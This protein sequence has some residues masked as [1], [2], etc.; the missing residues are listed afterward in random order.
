[1]LQ[2]PNN[3]SRGGRS[4]SNSRT[5]SPAAGRSNSKGGASK[6]SNGKLRNKLLKAA[7]RAVG[8][9]GEFEASSLQN[10]VRAAMANKAALRDGSLAT[11]N[12][13]AEV[14][15]L[16]DLQT[17]LAGGKPSG[18]ILRPPGSILR[19]TSLAMR[20][21]SVGEQKRRQSATSF[22]STEGEEEQNPRVSFLKPALK[23]GLASK[24][25]SAS[26]KMAME[27][28]EKQT[29][30]PPQSKDPATPKSIVIARD[31]M[32]PGMV[33]NAFRQVQV[34][35]V[36]TGKKESLK[37]D[38]PS[39]S[40]SST[41]GSQKKME[42]SKPVGL[43][44]N[45]AV[46]QLPVFK[47]CSEGFF[48][49][50]VAGLEHITLKPGEHR[51]LGG[52]KAGPAEQ[53]KPAA[54]VIVISGTCRVEIAGVPVEE[55]SA[56]QTFCLASAL[57]AGAGGFVST[58]TTTS[59]GA[60]GATSEAVV[61]ASGTKTQSP[62]ANKVP[63]SG[64]TPTP[65]PRSVCSCIFLRSNILRAAIQAHASDQARL[66]S[67]L[68]MLSRSVDG[69]KRILAALQCH[70]GAKTIVS[71][72][73]SRHIYM[74]GETIMSQG[75][76]NPDALLLILSG[77]V[78][79]D[80]GGVEVRRITE[81]QVIGEDMLLNVNQKWMYSGTCVTP[82]D[83]MVLYRKPF[84]ALVKEFPQGNSAEEMRELQRLLLLLEGR[85][86]EDRVILSLPLFRGLD[87]EFLATLAKLMETRVV[88]PGDKIWTSAGGGSTRWNSDEC[89]LFVLLHGSAEEHTIVSP[90][91]ARTRGD[92]FWSNGSGADGATRRSP[93][94]STSFWSNGPG[95]DGAT[96]RSSSKSASSKD[97]SGKDRDKDAKK[98]RRPLVPGAYGGS[99]EILGLQEINSTVVARTICLT[100]ILHRSVFVHACEQSRGNLEAPD[101]TK[102]LR[103]ELDEVEPLDDDQRPLSVEQLIGHIPVLRGHDEVFM[104]RLCGGGAQRFCMEGQHLCRA[105]VEASE[106]IVVLRGEIR[107]CMAGI[108]LAHVRRGKGINLLALASSGFIPNFDAVCTRATEVWALS[109]SELQATLEHFPAMKRIMAPLTAAQTKGIIFA[110]RPVRGMMEDADG[111][112]VT[113]VEHK[114]SSKLGLGDRGDR[115]ST[116]GDA[117]LLKGKLGSRILS[118]H[119]HEAAH[120]VLKSVQLFAGCSKEF[121]EWIR[122]HL[123]TK[124][125]F[126]DDIVF[127]E[128]EAFECLFLVCK[129]CIVWEGR[130]PDIS[131]DTQE[132][133]YAGS[134]LGEP[135]LLGVAEKANG[136]AVAIEPCLVQELH[137]K[138]LLLGLQAFPDQANHFNS[139]A[140]EWLNKTDGNVLAQVPF[141]KNCTEELQQQ[142]VSYARTRLI[143]AG[144]LIVEKAATTGPLCIIRSGTAVVE[145]G[146]R[147]RT[148]SGG[149]L[150]TADTSDLNL[151][152]SGGGVFTERLRKWDA[153]NAALVM[154]L[155]G[156]APASI[157]AETF[158]A[159]A[160]IDSH[161]FLTTLQRFKNQIPQ[162][163]RD[164][165][166]GHLWP[167]EVDSVP[168][169]RN[170]SQLFFNRL[171][172]V[173][174][175][176]MYL[177]DKN[178]V[179][180]GT[181]GSSMFLMCHGSAES[182]ID[183]VV[184]GNPLVPG[185]V[186]GKVNFL[187][188][189]DKYPTT[190]R[191]QTVCHFRVLK[192][193]HLN[194]LL[195]EQPTEREI[196]EHLKADEKNKAIADLERWKLEVTKEK[197]RRRVE[198]AFR[199]HVAVAKKNLQAES[200][201][202]AKNEKVSRQ[203]HMMMLLRR[204]SEKM[205]V[206]TGSPPLSV[207]SDVPSNGSSTP[208]V[209][210]PSDHG[211]QRKESIKAVKMMM[212]TGLGD[213]DSDNDES[214]SNKE[215]ESS[216][217]AAV[218]QFQVNDKRKSLALK[219]MIPGDS[220]QKQE[221]SSR[222]TVNYET[223]PGL[224]DVIKRHE[225]ALGQERDGKVVKLRQ[226]WLYI[227]EG[228][229]ETK[230]SDRGQS[231]EEAIDE[232]CNIRKKEKLRGRLLRLMRNGYPLGDAAPAGEDDSESSD[233]W[234][235]EDSGAG[236]ELEERPTAGM[237]KPPQTL[238]K[239]DLKKL[240]TLLPALPSSP[241]RTDDGDMPKGLVRQTL[242]KKF[243]KLTKVPVM[244]L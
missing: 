56:G 193:V 152:S 148:S 51:D 80:I 155:V 212:M 201:E 231:I 40:G 143:A 69:V 160:E 50:L 47:D 235:S 221:R 73:T 145:Y 34:D 168:F 118:S 196:F 66:R 150:A 191:T 130:G 36:S 52:R 20:R 14:D 185:D 63:I 147:Q 206:N 182:K 124:L 204:S 19:P 61:R 10:V 113:M 179:K 101:V 54:A 23:P 21:S 97:P 157:K 181:S 37:L 3:S 81:G 222:L 122:D 205:L 172:E 241:N 110:D 106:M 229:G 55:L 74:P 75:K 79:L 32:V 112:E 149:D 96:H 180:Q 31:S 225:V 127:R 53:A 90:K 108:T 84:T 107:T 214:E 120:F 199:K 109:R 72:S 71:R 5:P 244:T 200:E 28:S 136:S 43:T 13:V 103:E 159:V 232:F 94:K 198:L 111:G 169:F 213:S 178:V 153:A 85:W 158:C 190:I 220:P 167:G 35:K 117:K 99:R 226:K 238:S 76:R 67:V 224:G 46:R 86:K 210:I 6:D 129:G 77:T 116:K 100:A 132:S 104:E 126:P 58:R 166:G 207:G 27:L 202:S 183:G 39:P 243:R 146:P 234:D 91:R 218:D 60:A 102:L 119:D 187:G 203:L 33:R 29:P 137:R 25:P 123:E 209:R 115:R 135:H 16:E 121:R 174:D 194:M 176:A 163:V 70:E 170:V 114:R 242:F 189:T 105:G 22:A 87:G 211:V 223:I 142:L 64:S 237:R 228:D 140:I 184:V 45:R 192:T 98:V 48:A 208:G 151:A 173:S 65:T 4:G 219:L 83:V 128:G 144:E 230:G 59:A 171:V 38:P 44:A 154:G 24:A 186:I 82:C 15:D 41:F 134:T 156:K 78:T 197:R 7:Q 95:A 125:Y 93:S 18:G 9:G 233:S 26:E 161:I 88:F 30:R 11:E 57:A 8:R 62:A 12:G 195:P 175:W 141:L 131:Q 133:Y 215:E 42:Q 68:Q 240:D 239:K 188:V 177:P 165:I 49:Q 217:F 139:F 138:V 227:S 92:D 236:D 216:S 2:S 1:M 89:A 17:D 164:V 162:M